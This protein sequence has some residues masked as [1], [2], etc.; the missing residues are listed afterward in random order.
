MIDGL[1]ELGKTIFLTTHY[2]DEA[3]AL[4]DRIAVLSAGRI[5]AEGTP[6]TLGGRDQAAYQI[7]FTLP[8]RQTT[9]ARVTSLRNVHQAHT[10]RTMAARRPGLSRVPRRGGK[11]RRQ[12]RDLRGN[13]ERVWDDRA[14]W[15][16]TCSSNALV[17]GL[18]AKLCG[19]SRSE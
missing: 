17:R 19:P 14:P 11:P 5:V 4:A 8:D 2:M 3:E 1:R 12:P 18:R 15:R 7:S 16:A 13:R 9:A 6:V 10:T